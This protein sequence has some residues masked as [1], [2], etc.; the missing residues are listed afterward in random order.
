[1]EESRH[2]YKNEA[3]NQIK[4][5]LNISQQKI[6]SL[7]GVQPVLLANNHNQYTAISGPST[8]ITLIGS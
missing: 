5:L 4:F 3:N 6:V 8:T 1:M 7:E 2:K